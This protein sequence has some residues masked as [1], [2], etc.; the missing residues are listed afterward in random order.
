MT[1]SRFAVI[2][3]FEI[4]HP[5]HAWY[6]YLQTCF[7]GFPAATVFWLF[8]LGRTIRFTPIQGVLIGDSPVK[9]SKSYKNPPKAVPMKGQTIGTCSV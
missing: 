9:I 6:I 5:S 4:A 3:K 8:L 7:T 1:P 2:N